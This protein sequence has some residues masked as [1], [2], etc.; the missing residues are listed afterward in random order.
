MIKKGHIIFRPGRVVNLSRGEYDRFGLPGDMPARKA[1]FIAEQV[2]LVSRID[3][4]AGERH[5]VIIADDEKRNLDRIAEKLE[6]L[7]FSGR[8]PVRMYVGNVGLRTEIRESRLSEF[9]VIEPGSSFRPADRSAFF[10]GGALKTK[11][12]LQCEGAFVS[13]RGA[14]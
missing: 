4:P 13:T 14:K 11:V 3:L 2:Q 6:G 7:A 5:N 9:A 1:N 8:Y 10:P 12:A